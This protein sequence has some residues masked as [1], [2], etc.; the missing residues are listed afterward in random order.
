MTYTTW[1][2]VFARQCSVGYPY[3]DEEDLRLTYEFLE[4]NKH[5]FDRISLSKFQLFEMAPLYQQVMDDIKQNQNTMVAKFNHNIVMLTSRGSKYSAYKHKVLR[6][7]NKIN[8]KPLMKE[9]IVYDGI[10]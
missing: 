6:Q 1:V 10:M 9:A 8:S 7:V 5:C 2:S 3:E 4:R